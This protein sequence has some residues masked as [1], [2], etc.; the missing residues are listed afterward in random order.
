MLIYYFFRSAILRPGLSVG[1]AAG[2]DGASRLDVWTTPC[3]PAVVC[4]HAPC[5]V[6]YQA[7]R[8]QRAPCSRSRLPNGFPPGVSARRQTPVRRA[9]RQGPT[10]R[11]CDLFD[12][13]RLGSVLCFKGTGILFYSDGSTIYFIKRN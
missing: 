1:P 8:A 7:G 4:G 10:E 11:L 6:C 2:R 5:R 9:E 12:I 13:Q 3:S